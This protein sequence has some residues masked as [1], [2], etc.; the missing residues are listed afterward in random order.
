MTTIADAVRITD[1]GRVKSVKALKALVTPT[2]SPVEAFFTR[3]E[4]ADWYFSYSDDANMWRRGKEQIEA[5]ERD[6]KASPTFQAI[7]DA[8]N[9]YTSGPANR[10]R[11]VLAQIITP[12]VEETPVPDHIAPCVDMLT[13][14]IDLECQVRKGIRAHLLESVSQDDR[15]SVGANLMLALSRL[16][17]NGDHASEGPDFFIEQ[18]IRGAS[19]MLT[20]P[21]IHIQA[22]VEFDAPAKIRKPATAKHQPRTTDGES[23]PVTIKD[24]KI[25]MTK[26][27]MERAITAAVDAR[28]AER[29]R[30]I[31]SIT[32]TPP[33]DKA[34]E[35]VKKGGGRA[36][37]QRATAA[38]REFAGLTLAAIVVSESLTIPALEMGEDGV[39]TLVTPKIR[40]PY[41]K[42]RY[43]LDKEPVPLDNETT[44][45]RVLMTEHKRIAALVDAKPV[46]KTSTPKVV[47]VAVAIDTDAK[48]VRKAKI[49]ALMSV[50]GITKDEAKALVG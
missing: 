1:H 48:A 33:A 39:D 8:W 40:S 7:Y 46:A 20:I 29:E 5:I 50:M 31:R 25:T 34:V 35:I 41:N 27:E 38:D 45:Y 23:H 17:A 4:R 12:D 36:K 2:E 37:I 3:C 28:I 42:A 24:T 32:P 22:R 14:C 6:A 44:T 49:K 26:D 18:A 11:P 16:L 30:T 13:T 47:L 15:P 10:V 21:S 43:R 19:E 9:T